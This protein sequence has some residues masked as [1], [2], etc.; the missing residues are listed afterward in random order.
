MTEPYCHIPEVSVARLRDENPIIAR[1]W[2]RHAPDN[3]Q[4]AH[5]MVE[6]YHQGPFTACLLTTATETWVGIAKQCR[7]AD[8]ADEDNPARGEA[9]A[10][11]RA[12]QNASRVAGSFAWLKRLI[13]GEPTG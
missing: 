8:R 11:S 5:T 2:E 12:L 10:F 1:I 7:Y 6:F 9:I 13:F 3:M 4:I